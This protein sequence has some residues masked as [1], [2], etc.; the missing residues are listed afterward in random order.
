[1]KGKIEELHE[2]VVSQLPLFAAQKPMMADEVC[3]MF[4][5]RIICTNLWAGY[6]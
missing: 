5:T 4:S 1:M 2:S 3:Y 6:V